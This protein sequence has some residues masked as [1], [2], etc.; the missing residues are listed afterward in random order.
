MNELS[1]LQDKGQ[2]L[3]TFSLNG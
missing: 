2:D 3:V 1:A